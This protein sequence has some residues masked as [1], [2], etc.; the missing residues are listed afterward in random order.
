MYYFQANARDGGLSGGCDSCCC[1]PMSAKQGETNLIQID[2]APW[3]VPIGGRGLTCGTAFQV[4]KVKSCDVPVSG[5]QRPVAQPYYGLTD[6]NTNLVATVSSLV[7][8]A[9]SDALTF[10]HLPLYG[11]SH[12]TLVMSSDGSF[13]Y[14]PGINFS[15]YDHFYYSVSDGKGRDVIQEGVIGVHPADPLPALAMPTASR[16]TEIVKVESQSANVLVNH[17]LLRFPISVAPNAV[18]GDVYRM[19]VRQRASDC[20]GFC[21]SHEM[22]FDLLIS[23]C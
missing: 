5:N 7:T 16:L 1:T 6:F 15:G 11:P 18:L 9:E 13:V 12:G 23:K 8:D 21:Y 19:T 3:S 22:C 20:E 14:T 2:Y 17:H 10:K 4:E